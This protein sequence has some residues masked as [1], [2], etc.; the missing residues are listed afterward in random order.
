MRW[1]LETSVVKKDDENYLQEIQCVL[2][3]ENV[4][5]LNDR[6]E[7]PNIFFQSNTYTLESNNYN[8]TENYLTDF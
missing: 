8:S 2:Y 4:F 1:P 6:V 3:W 7:L 5:I